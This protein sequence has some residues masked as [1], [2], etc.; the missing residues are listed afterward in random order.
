MKR[1]VIQIAM[2]AEAKGV[3]EQLKLSEIDNPFGERLPWR[4][5]EGEVEGAVVVVVRPGVDERFKVD[6]IG[7]QPAAVL[8]ELAIR[9]FKPIVLV[10]AGTAGGFSSKGAAVGEVYV[11][12]DKLCF[13]DRRIAIPGFDAFGVGSY[14]CADMSKMAVELKLKQGI[15]TTGNALDLPDADLAVMKQTGGEV[16]EMEAA[17]IAWVCAMHKVP[18]VAIKSITDLVDGEHPNEEEFLANLTLASERLTEKLVE[19]VRWFAT[20]LRDNIEA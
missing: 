14:P 2:E 16:K 18:F 1:I 9:E 8:A 12:K 15:V 13:H 10:N 5:Y 20:H 19:V 4:A 3:V 11:S 6:Q 7:T 17:A